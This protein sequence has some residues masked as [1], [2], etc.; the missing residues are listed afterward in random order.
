MSATQTTRGGSKDIGLEDTSESFGLP[1]RPY[2]CT[3]FYRELED[4]NQICV[5]QLNRYNDPTV[6]KRFVV[7]IDRAK[8]RL[9]DVEQE[10]QKDLVDSG[11]ENEEPVFDNTPFAGKTSKYEKFSDIK[12]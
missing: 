11:Q 8:M 5:K 7:G 4:L 2:I 1:S 9:Y 3:H 10:A 6:N 12:V